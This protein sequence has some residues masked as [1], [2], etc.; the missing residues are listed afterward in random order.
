MEGL[1]VPCSARPNYLTANLGRNRGKESDP[2]ALLLVW[3]IN[4]PSE[5]KGFD[6]ALHHLSSDDFRYGDTAIIFDISMGILDSMGAFS[7]DATSALPNNAVYPQ[8]LERCAQGNNTSMANVINMLVAAANQLVTSPA[9]ITSWIDMILQRGCW[10]RMQ[11]ISRYLLN[12]SACPLNYKFTDVVAKAVVSLNE[13]AQ[14]CVLECSDS[15]NLVDICMRCLKDIEERASNNEPQRGLLTGFE[16]LDQKLNGLHAGKLYIVA[17]RPAVGKTAFALNVMEHIVPSHSIPKPILFFSLEM[18]NEEIGLRTLST[19]MR[20]ATSD[21]EY[22]RLSSEQK[23]QGYE[24]LQNLDYSSFNKDGSQNICRVLVDDNGC[25]SPNL[26]ATKVRQVADENGGVAMIVIDYLQLM[27][28]DSMS[29]GG[30]RNLEL[31]NISRQLKLMAK[32]YSCPVLALSQLNRQIE[33]RDDPTPMLSDLR[34][35]GAI[36]QDADAVMFLS[37]PKEHKEGEQGEIEGRVLN[38]AKNRSGPVG[39]INLNFRGAWTL[40]TESSAD[41]NGAYLLSKDSSKAK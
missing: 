19:L 31:A 16:E 4:R 8:L 17:A 23:Q 21:I 12:V 26:L 20:A 10:D 18:G 13:M 24:R 15:Q 3:M 37:K 22:C 39:I 11:E 9:V 32:E 35:S 27:I 29:F 1:R 34:D 41:R 28:N 40:F 5:V 6:Q 38:L 14:R 25:L 2:E 33:N 36:E 7:A 30:N